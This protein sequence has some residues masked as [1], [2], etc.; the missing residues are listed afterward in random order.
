MKSKLYLILFLIA[1]GCFVFFFLNND[2]FDISEEI[3][4]S[5]S[6]ESNVSNQ[7][8]NF[9]E[10]NSNSSGELGREYDILVQ[11][12]NITFYDKN[13]NSIIYVFS[14]DRLENVL[15]VFNLKSI[16]EANVIAAYYK[17]MVG[18]GKIERVVVKDTIVSVVLDMEQFAE[19]RNYSRESLEE[20]LLKDTNLVEEE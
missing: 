19:Y 1:V 18:N 16:E 12:D 4:F 10:N 13:G 20:I 5:E 15:N 7:E 6:G 3:I 17:A 2:F 9:V 11:D 8:N 14:N